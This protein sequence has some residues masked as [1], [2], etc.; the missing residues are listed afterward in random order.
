MI[1]RQ[2]QPSDLIQIQRWWIDHHGHSSPVLYLSTLGWIVDNIACGFFYETNSSE[3]YLEYCVSNP[4]STHDE[5]QKAMNLLMDEA[6][7]YAKVNNFKRIFAITKTSGI[8]KLLSG[9]GYEL[10]HTDMKIFHR[11]L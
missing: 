11:S 5:R 7:K 4:S 3:C 9:R 2:V 10:S 1:A 8:E 6:E